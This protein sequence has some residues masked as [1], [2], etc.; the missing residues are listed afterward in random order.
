MTPEQKNAFE[1]RRHELRLRH[2]ANDPKLRKA[3]NKR[4]LSVL[5]AVLGAFVTI[6]VMLMLT[7]SFMVAVHGPDEYT[8]IVAPALSHDA[9]DSLLNTILMPDPVSTEVAAILRPF[10]PGQGDVAGTRPTEP[11]AEPEGDSPEA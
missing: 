7:K 4:R 11:V 10:L 6:G 1:K 8:R 5:T 2:L 3:R 9:P